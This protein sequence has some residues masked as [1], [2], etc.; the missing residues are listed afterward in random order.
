MN[1]ND[2]NDHGEFNSEIIGEEKEIEL[3]YRRNGNPKL[4]QTDIVVLC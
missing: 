1:G 4:N 2:S 3:P